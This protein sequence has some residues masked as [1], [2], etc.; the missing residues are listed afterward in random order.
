MSEYSQLQMKESRKEQY[1]ESQL[2][3]GTLFSVF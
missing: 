3:R 2:F 1:Y